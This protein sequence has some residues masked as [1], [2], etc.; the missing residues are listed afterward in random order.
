MFR[1]VPMGKCTVRFSGNLR[2]RSTEFQDSHQPIWGGPRNWGRPRNVGSYPDKWGCPSLHG[3]GRIP[4]GSKKHQCRVTNISTGRTKGGNRDNGTP[5]RKLHVAPA[6]L[7]AI[8]NQT[9]LSDIRKSIVRSTIL[10]MEYNPYSAALYVQK[11]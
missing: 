4:E 6:D 7:R 11:K 3:T 8:Y 10:I 2:C 1:H 5:S 9:D